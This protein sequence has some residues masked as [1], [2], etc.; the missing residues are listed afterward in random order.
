MLFRSNINALMLV[1]YKAD[2][3]AAVKALIAAGTDVNAK[4]NE[5]RTVLMCAADGGLAD[6]VGQ[7][8]KAGARVNAQDEVGRTALMWAAHGRLIPV[9]KEHRKIVQML[10]DAGAD[11]KKKDH[12]GHTAMTWARYNRH[13]QIALMLK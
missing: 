7:I 6:A 9:A 10:L 2:A 8:V 1:V 3:A 11:R 13:E 5:G 4:D 12:E